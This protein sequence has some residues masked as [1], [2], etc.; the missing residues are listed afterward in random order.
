MAA[1]WNPLHPSGSSGMREHKGK[2]YVVLENGDG[3]L[4]VYRILNS[5]VLKQLKRWPAALE[6][7]PVK[8]R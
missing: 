2:Q 3:V 1:V 4:A 7:E 5:G 8:V 6:G